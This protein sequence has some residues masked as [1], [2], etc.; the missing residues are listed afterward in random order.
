MLHTEADRDTRVEPGRSALQRRDSLV[1]S[2]S[3]NRLGAAMET[4]VSVGTD[5]RLIRSDVIRGKIEAMDIAFSK[6]GEP[7]F[8][9]ENQANMKTRSARVTTVSWNR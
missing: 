7:L 6:M 1:R 9:K 3:R 8:G 4:L 5:E 2:V